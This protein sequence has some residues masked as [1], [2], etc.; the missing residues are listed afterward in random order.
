MPRRQPTA[1]SILTDARRAGWESVKLT[2]DAEGRIAVECGRD[3][4]DQEPADPWEKFEAKH[5]AENV[6][7]SAPRHR[8]RA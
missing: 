3:T 7:L 1:Y 4:Q 8:K 2:F 5:A 6:A